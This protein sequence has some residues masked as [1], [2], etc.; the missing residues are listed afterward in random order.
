MFKRSIKTFI[1]CFVLSIMCVLSVNAASL[2]SIVEPGDIIIG[3]TVFR[4]DDWISATRSSKAG[5]LY[6]MNTGETEVRVFYYDDFEDWYEYNDATSKYELITVPTLSELG[7]IINIYYDN[8]EPLENT[9]VSSYDEELE[10]GNDVFGF[11]N[12]LYG[13]IFVEDEEVIID[14]ENETITCPY[15]KVF[16][17]EVVENNEPMEFKGVCGVDDFEFYP[18]E[19]YNLQKMKIVNIEKT[20]SRDELINQDKVDFEY[21]SY[22]YIRFQINEPIEETSVNIA[23]DEN[24]GEELFGNIFAFDITFEENNVCYM[25]EFMSMD[26]YIQNYTVHCL[27][28]NTMRVYL[29]LQSYGNTYFSFMLLDY[30]FEAY[31]NI[32]IYSDGLDMPMKE[33]T[34]DENATTNNSTI[35]SIIEENEVDEYGQVHVNVNTIGNFE[36]NSHDGVEGKWIAIDFMFE[37]YVPEHQVSVNAYQD[38]NSYEHLGDGVRVYLNM[39][40]EQHKQIPLNIH[41]SYN[42]NATTYY[43]HINNFEEDKYIENF[44]SPIEKIYVDMVNEDNS[45][46]FQEVD[47]AYSHQYLLKDD[48]NSR[49]YYSG[50][51]TFFM[52]SESFKYLDFDDN[53]ENA[54]VKELNAVVKFITSESSGWSDFYTIENSDSEEGFFNQINSVIDNYEGSEEE[55]RVEI[56]KYLNPNTDLTNINAELDKFADLINAGVV[57]IWDSS[58]NIYETE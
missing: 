48:E 16:D 32:N 49:L 39:D 11:F 27:D 51:R 9:Y 7:D 17:F 15:Q 5:A 30:E 8:N 47:S 38:F 54:T 2:E 24:S 53:W 55:I 31:K 43:L 41:V 44:T 19:F 57:E 18:S 56:Y 29:D 35:Y 58:N 28:D 10:I 23:Y 33:I 1:L 37:N 21:D 34:F 25:Y 12:Y 3:N 40:N 50:L 45:F 22:D 13:D 26:P 42:N 20:D 6:S 36:T 46:Y 52:D 4:S 14:Y